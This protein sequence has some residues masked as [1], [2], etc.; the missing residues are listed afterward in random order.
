MLTL[1]EALA[2]QGHCFSNNAYLHAGLA[3]RVAFSLGLHVDKYSLSHGIV[4]KEHAR[5]I[6]W[7]L[8]NFDQEIALRTGK[9]CSISEGL[10][11]DP[12]EFPS[13]HV[14]EKFESDA[15]SLTCVDPQLG[16]KHAIL[17]LPIVIF[18]HEL[19]QADH[20]DLIPNFNVRPCCPITSL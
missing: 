17:L 15:I 18:A 3:V 11:N 6:W 19:D 12:P 10:I 8:Y 20:P 5:A 16:T 13:E 2:L 1:T 7:T 4:D 9:P 14:S